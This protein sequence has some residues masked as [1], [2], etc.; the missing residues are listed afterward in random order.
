MADPVAYNFTVREGYTR[1]LHLA[2]LAAN[3]DPFN[4]TSTTVEFIAKE[5]STSVTVAIEYSLV[6]DGS[7]VGV[8]DPTGRMAL[9]EPDET[10]PDGALVNTAATTG[11]VTITFDPA[12]SE[13]LATTADKTYSYEV[14]V[15]T[16]TQ[17]HLLG[18]G[19][20]TV[21]DSLFSD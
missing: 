16:A 17:K 8:S 6:V 3:G 7:G 13:E 12:D 5:K 15:T 21:K 9:G 19:T 18:F 10:D 4:F 2:A 14:R 1:R 20:I 11:N